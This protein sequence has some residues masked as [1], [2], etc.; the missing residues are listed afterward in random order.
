MDVKAVNVG[1]GLN[2]CEFPGWENIDNSP[3]ARLSKHPILRRLA[4]LS[5]VMPKQLAEVPWPRCIRIHDATESLPYPDSSLRCVYSSHF[6]EH[7]TPDVAERFLAHCYRVLEPGGILRVVVPDF[8]LLVDEYLR[9]SNGDGEERASA[10][11]RFLLATGLLG[12]PAVGSKCIR[13]LRG[14]WGRDKHYWQYDEYSLK[15]R[16]ERVGFKN[17]TRRPFGE[18]MIPE[19]A[20]LDIPVRAAE[21]LYVEGQKGII[22]A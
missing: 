6:V 15:A 19:V 14:L 12:K 17:V 5:G 20:S 1:C 7:N 10:V 22:P 18:S 4:R 16:L 9:S 21:S 3:N 8:K 11:D 2:V 13:V